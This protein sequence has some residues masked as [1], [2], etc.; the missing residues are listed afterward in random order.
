MDF[1]QFCTTDQGPKRCFVYLQDL[2]EILMTRFTADYQLLN[3]CIIHFSNKISDLS[4]LTFV[5]PLTSESGKIVFPNLKRYNVIYGNDESWLSGR[6]GIIAKPAI[7]TC[8]LL[9]GV[10][11][12]LQE[13]RILTSATV[14]HQGGIKVKTHKATSVCKPLREQGSFHTT[15]KLFTDNSYT[16]EL[17]NNDNENVKQRKIDWFEDVFYEAS[18]LP[19]HENLHVLPTRCYATPHP[20]PNSELQY[21]YISQGLVL[22]VLCSIIG[23][24]LCKGLVKSL[25]SGENIS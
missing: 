19:V 6:I 15:L 9:I 17:D 7:I 16:K 12:A 23:N 18:L 25:N 11:E 2:I 3:T 22:K 4:N 5:L 14:Q 10:G 21:T 13:D 1:L 8:P 24:L 20:D